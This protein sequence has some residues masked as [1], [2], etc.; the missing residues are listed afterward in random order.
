MLF[1]GGLVKGINISKRF[2]HLP[3]IMSGGKDLYTSLQ[4]QLENPNL[5]LLKTNTSPHTKLPWLVTEIHYF[6]VCVFLNLP[7]TNTDCVPRTMEKITVYLVHCYAPT[8]KLCPQQC[9][10]YLLGVKKKRKSC[11]KKRQEKA[12]GEEHGL[13]GT[14]MQICS[15]WI[16]KCYFLHCQA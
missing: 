1:R 13:L 16:F 10:K 7:V 11:K 8:F 9:C 12:E 14:T 5:I 15:T 4:L 6:F 3:Q 2:L